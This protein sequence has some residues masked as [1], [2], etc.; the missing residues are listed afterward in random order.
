MVYN[1][2]FFFLADSIIQRIPKVSCLLKNGMAG[3]CRIIPEIFFLRT[4]KLGLTL[5]TALYK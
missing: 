5:Y 3:I 2:F 4:S 1:F